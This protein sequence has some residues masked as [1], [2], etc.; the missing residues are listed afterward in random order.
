MARAE[1][2]ALLVGGIPGETAEEVFRLVGPIIGDLAIGLTDG[3]TGARRGWVLFIAGG[4]WLNHPQLKMVRPSR[5]HPGAPDIVPGVLKLPAGYDDL[6][7]FEPEPGITV[8]DTDDHTSGYVDEAIASYAIFCRLRKEGIIPEGVR[9]Q[10][11]IPFPDDAVRLFCN[12]VSDMAILLEAY[13]NIIK[14]DLKRLCDA[15][16]HEDLLLQWDI[17]WETVAIEHGDYMP[18]QP[19]FQFQP[20]VPAMDRF[21]RYIRD[22]NSSVPEGVKLG[23]HLCYGD[24]NN[25]HFKDPADLAASVAMA[26]AA[27]AESPRAIN[28]IHMTVPVNRNDDPYFEPLGDLNVGDTP[29]YAGLIHYKDGV[30][31]SLERLKA[32]KRHYDGPTGVTTECGLGRRP[33]EERIETWF[34]IYRELVAHL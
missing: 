16:P 27:V 19:P 14:N 1:R 12:S 2:P 15:I 18:D 33:P 5:G 10:Q 9:F 8:L 13:L 17:N 34:D 3:E 25:V 7:W 11:C 26:N 23:L 31:G 32:F 28:S 22:L 6:P 24:L 21:C 29:V 4:L 30:K 20:D